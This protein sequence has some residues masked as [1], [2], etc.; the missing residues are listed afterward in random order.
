MRHSKLQVSTPTDAAE[1]EAERAANAIVSRVPFGVGGAASAIHRDDT[2]Q[3]VPTPA[4]GQATPVV[5]GTGTTPGAV[6]PTGGTAAAPTGGTATTVDTLW[7]IN[8]IDQFAG[9]GSKI[10]GRSPA[11]SLYVK[12]LKVAPQGDAGKPAP[13]PKVFKGVTLAATGRAEM[14]S[15][16]HPKDKAGTVSASVAYGARPTFDFTI[17]TVD[18]NP[19]TASKEEKGE[20]AKA[21]AMNTGEA[22]KAVVKEL[23]DKLDTFVDE[24]EAQQVLTDIVNAKFQDISVEAKIKMTNAKT[25]TPINTTDF[26]YPALS[27]DKTF[28]LMVS[29]PSATKDRTSSY[30]TTK[31]GETSQGTESSTGETKEKGTS[32]KTTVET[33][34][35]QSF[36]SAFSSELKT[37]AEEV[38]T[39]ANLDENSTKHTGTMS[40]KNSS[41]AKLSGDINGSAGLD[42]DKIPIA[43][44]ILGKLLDAKVNISLKPDLSDVFELE[45]ISTD[46]DAK[47]TV[48]SEEDKVRNELATAMM[49]SVKSAWSSSLKTQVENSTHET[50][51]ETKGQKTSEAGKKAESTSATTTTGTVTIVANVVQPVLSEETAPGG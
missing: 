7:N 15:Y 6:T 36:E 9:T 2:Q 43:G 1:V 46:E 32:T 41:S 5:T 31:G 8:F 23:T 29:I 42:L 35:L 19:Q 25:T 14:G 16:A 20:A 21:K 30:T 49:S 37:A 13:A 17:K 38:K 44:K 48:K 50:T 12:E 39:K 40:V 11:T 3:P 24:D 4:P 47:K 34:F 26:T 27:A 33:A 22:H 10:E 28:N 45:H 18:Y 51:T